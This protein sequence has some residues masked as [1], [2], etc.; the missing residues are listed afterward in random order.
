MAITTKALADGKHAVVE[1]N[2]VSAVRTGNIAAQY[3]AEVKL[4]NGMALSVDHSGKKVKVAEDGKPVYLHASDEQLYED[5]VGRDA[6]YIKEGEYPK[7]LLLEVG[8]I[9]ETDAVVAGAYNA[10]DVVG[11]TAEGLWGKDSTI[12]TIEA[13]VAEGIYLPNGKAGLKIA[14]TKVASA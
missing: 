2:H 3:V 5:H 14:I 10:G 13:V 1:T 7:A 6:F 8:D 4:D 11:P 9:F 12:T